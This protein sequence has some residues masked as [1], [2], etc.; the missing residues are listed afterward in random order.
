M[1]KEGGRRGRDGGRGR[2]KKRGKREG[3][4]TGKE[5]GRRDGGRGRDMI[6]K[7]STVS[8]ITAFRIPQAHFLCVTLFKPTRINP[9]YYEDVDTY[10]SHSFPLFSLTC[11]ATMI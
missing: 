7:I 9:S 6:G 10:S 4:E 1:G 3:E 5:G 2:E 8:E 11:S